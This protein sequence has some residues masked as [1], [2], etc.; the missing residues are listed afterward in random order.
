MKQNLDEYSKRL[1][2]LYEYKYYNT[3]TEEDDEPQD[4]NQDGG[5]SLEMGDDI[6]DNGDDNQ[7]QDDMSNDNQDDSQ[8]FDDSF[9][10]AAGDDIEDTSDDSSNDFDEFSDDGTGGEEDVEEI[11]VSGIVDGVDKNAVEIQNVNQKLDTVSSKFQSYIDKIIQANS[12][13]TQQV[14][15][16]EKGISDISNEFKK[17]NPTPNEQLNLRSL[18]SYPYNQKLTDYWQ[19]S[20]QNS[21]ETMPNQKYDVKINDDKTPKEYT[22]TDKDVDDDYSEIDVKNSL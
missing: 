3:L 13:L 14:K 10:D 22:L 11:D 20:K 8:D 6:E 2:K 1:Q 9:D 19:P 15:T 17:R 5:D 4:D 21:V 18:S 7:N 12:S 16:L